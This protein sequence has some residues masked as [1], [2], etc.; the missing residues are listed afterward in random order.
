MQGNLELRTSSQQIVVA[1]QPTLADLTWS[2]NAKIDD[3]TI[4]EVYRQHF[5][6]SLAVQNPHVL[7]LRRV[8]S[9]QKKHPSGLAP[10]QPPLLPFLHLRT[11]I[12]CFEADRAP[13][14]P[15]TRILISALLKGLDLLNEA[16]DTYSLPCKVLW[17][18]AVRRGAFDIANEIRLQ[19]LSTDSMFT[20]QGRL[21]ESHF[22]QPKYCDYEIGRL[23]GVECVI[24]AHACLLGPPPNPG[25]MLLA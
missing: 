12:Y 10:N 2:R 20:D 3:E 6:L 14:V 8:L 18:W 22:Q 4:I 15:L 19:L 9:F 21:T 17:E 11:L 16:T 13:V 25:T 5:F 23:K 24:Q 7:L 1:A